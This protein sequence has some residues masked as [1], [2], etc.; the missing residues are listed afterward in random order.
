MLNPGRNVRVSRRN[1]L[2]ALTA[3]GGSLAASLFLPGKWDKPLLRVGV[4]PVHAQTS[5]PQPGPTYAI[6][7][8]TLNEDFGDYCLWGLSATI[9]PAAAGVEMQVV[10]C[11]ATESCQTMTAVTDS[12]GVATFAEPDPRCF[13]G[14]G[15][16]PVTVTFSFVNTSLCSGANCTVEYMCSETGCTRN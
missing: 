5:N 14:T 13:P 4:L 2:K 6:A 10:I 12:S 1:L 11:D 16:L 3:A 9:T 15:A 8:T 7:N